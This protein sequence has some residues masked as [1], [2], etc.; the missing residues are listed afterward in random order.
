VSL[1]FPFWSC[2]PWLFVRCLGIYRS[3]LMAWRLGIDSLACQ[4]DKH[5]WGSELSRSSFIMAKGPTV[6]HEMASSSQKLAR[7]QG[8]QG[9]G[10]TRWTFGMEETIPERGGWNRGGRPSGG[11]GE[12]LPFSLDTSNCE[13]SMEAARRHESSRHSTAQHSQPAADPLLIARVQSDSSGSPSATTR[14]F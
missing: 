4:S 3:A 2:H 5:S 13:G 10:S 14:P 1:G 11:G 8:I 12:E 6:S 7:S 9:Q